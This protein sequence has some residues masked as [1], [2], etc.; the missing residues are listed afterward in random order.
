MP[1]ACLIFTHLGAAWR[2]G[3]PQEELLQVSS[4]VQSQ[5]WL[6]VV[7]HSQST[8]LAEVAALGSF[9]QRVIC[10]EERWVGIRKAEL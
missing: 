7:A 4:D 6:R 3:L 5:P 2:K 8:Y 10:K 9:Y 1:E